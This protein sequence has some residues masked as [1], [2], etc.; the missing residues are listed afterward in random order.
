MLALSVM[1]INIHLNFL[2]PKLFKFK[3]KLKYFLKNKK[4]IYFYRSFKKN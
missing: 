2:N 4:I 3:L 1:G